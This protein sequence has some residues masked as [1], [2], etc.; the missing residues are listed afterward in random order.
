V[1]DKPSPYKKGMRAYA[2]GDT[3]CSNPYRRGTPNWESWLGG[4]RNASE[5]ARQK[6]QHERETLE[7]AWTE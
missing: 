7:R 2:E 4:W 6:Q 5:L 1:S 3:E